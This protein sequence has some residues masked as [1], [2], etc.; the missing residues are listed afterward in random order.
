MTRLIIVGTVLTLAVG[1][2]LALSADE[3]EVTIKDVMKKAHGGKPSLKDKVQTGK[4]SDDEKKMLL[5]LYTALSKNKPPKGDEED[6]KKRTED[7]VAAAKAATE[8]KK[9]ATQLLAKA[10]N[11]AACHKLHKP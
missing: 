1:G 3:E 2:T 9:N 10:T 4:A 7:L 5:E 8:G 6:F 11:C